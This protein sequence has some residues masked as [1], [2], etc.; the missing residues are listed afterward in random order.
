MV[1]LHHDAEI[2]P[3]LLLTFEDSETAAEGEKLLGLF[4]IG[5]VEDAELGY[6]KLSFIPLPRESTAKVV[7]VPQ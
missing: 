5:K 7:L 4:T 2:V 1:G 6:Q 3:S